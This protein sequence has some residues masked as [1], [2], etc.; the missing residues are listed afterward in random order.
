MDFVA[1]PVYRREKTCSNRTDTCLLVVHRFI[2]I[3][4][5]YEHKSKKLINTYS[6][7]KNDL[8]L[9]GP[10]YR[11]FN[12]LALLSICNTNVYKL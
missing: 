8:Q 3:F 5:S 9:V 7:I 4:K 2:F 12:M 11:N 6:I 10:A 1:F